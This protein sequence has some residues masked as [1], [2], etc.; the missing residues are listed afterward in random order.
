MGKFKAACVCEQMIK[1]AYHKY[2][3]YALTLTLVTVPI[4]ASS[5]RMCTNYISKKTTENKH[6]AINKW[7]KKTQSR[8]DNVCARTMWRT[9]QFIWLNKRRRK[10]TQTKENERE[11]QTHK[12]NINAQLKTCYIKIQFF[13]EI[14]KRWEK[15]KCQWIEW[16]SHK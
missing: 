8:I 7:I 6:T 4:V 13:C 9:P 3:I 5:I 11:E 14:R 2:C 12:R 16:S 15:N 1:S 10:N